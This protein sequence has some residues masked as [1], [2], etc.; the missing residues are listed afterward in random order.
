MLARLS[1]DLD[2]QSARADLAAA[3]QSA[4]EALAIASECGD[5]AIRSEAEL[6]LAWIAVRMGVAEV[7]LRAYDDVMPRLSDKRLRA[8]ALSRRSV[9]RQ[10]C[11]DPDGAQE[12]LAAAFSAWDE[13]GDPSV[14]ERTLTM[15]CAG[16]IAFLAGDTA[17]ATGHLQGAIRARRDAG[18]S[19]EATPFELLAHVTAKTGDHERALRLAGIA[20][21]LRDEFGLWVDP[22][23]VLGDRSWLAGLERDLGARAGRLCADGRAMSD[24]DAVAYAL[25]E[26][27]ADPLTGRERAVADLVAEGLSNKEIAARLRI[28]ART[29]ENHVQRLRDKLGLR[30]RAQI[31]LW[32]KH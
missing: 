2:H 22:Q 16:E 27:A 4:A 1:T 19:Q 32:A 23:F 10:V 11:G 26:R 29:A 7:G 24:V 9:L 15:F 21:R 8:L 30:S 17:E 12:D 13:H 14:T 20:E 3:R 5:A 6:A 25:G 31:A 18:E 28:S